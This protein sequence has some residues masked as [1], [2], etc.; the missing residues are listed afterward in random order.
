[1][2]GPIVSQVDRDRLTDADV[3]VLDDRIGTGDGAMC[4][5]VVTA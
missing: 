5:E 1:M 4:D 2:T 3:A